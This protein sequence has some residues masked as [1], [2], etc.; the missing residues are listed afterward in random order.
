MIY[1]VTFNPAIDYV[2]S[3]PEFVEGKINRSSEEE[4]FVGGKGIN[5]SIMLHRLG[6]AS[7]ALGFTAGFTGKA[8]ENDLME[9]GIETDF[10][11]LKNGR[12][13]INVKIKAEL[14]SEING[15][16]PV[17]GKEAVDML[18]TKLDDLIEGD[19]LVL[20]GSIPNSLPNDIYEQ[21][22]CRLNSKK[23]MLVIDA[24]GELLLNVL[25]YRPFLVK[26]NHHELGEM[27]GTEITDSEKARYYAEKLKNKGAENVL[28]SMAENGAV[29]LDSNGNFHQINAPLGK[30]VNSVGAGDSMVAGFLAGYTERKN[31]EYALSLGI[32]AGSATA[33]SK[34]LSEK[35]KVY[36]ILSSLIKI[37]F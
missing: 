36:E 24:S 14:E 9:Q 32:A 21:I 16:G 33:F 6:I 37:D 13:R 31:Y 20:A 28:V 15:I 2:I 30:V 3:L 27:F 23:I 25:Q 5:V 26:P 19:T 12:S 18:F 34:G 1:T 17:V 8:I 11:H 4:I 10:I 35:E 29:L 7:K 22:A